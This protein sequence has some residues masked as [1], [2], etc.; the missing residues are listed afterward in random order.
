MPGLGGPWATPLAA[1]VLDWS[2]THIR[3]S[4][5]K[6]AFLKKPCPA[7]SQHERVLDV[8]NPEK[9]KPWRFL[10]KRI[11]LANCTK[12]DVGSQIHY[13]A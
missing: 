1:W 2:R 12:L 6:C 10:V 9:K 8:S 3:Y 11:F 5:Q 7:K 4:P 13:V